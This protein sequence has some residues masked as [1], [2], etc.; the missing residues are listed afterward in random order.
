MARM[1]SPP[2]AGRITRATH[3]LISRAFRTLVAMN[4][5]VVWM[6]VRRSVRS[7]VAAAPRLNWSAR[8]WLESSEGDGA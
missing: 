3:R 4:L 7:P 1:R 2:R 5:E 8:T 6:A